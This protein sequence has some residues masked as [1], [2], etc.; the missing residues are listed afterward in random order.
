MPGSVLFGLAHGQL[1]AFADA[2]EAGKADIEAARFDKAKHASLTR[3][4]ERFACQ[5]AEI[6]RVLRLHCDVVGDL[7]ATGAFENYEQLQQELRQSFA[8]GKEILE[9][10]LGLAR[11]FREI[12]GSLESLEILESAA[13]EVRQMVRQLE[14][15]F[16]A[17]RGDSI[18]I[19]EAFARISG[20]SQEKW[21]EQVAARKAQS[22]K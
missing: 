3:N 4:L 5:C 9:G 6:P 11:L 15:K 7:I 14:A 20:V 8:R 22:K 13:E 18:E 19:D 1:A 2:I 21:L 17:Q 16:F 10:I 12:G